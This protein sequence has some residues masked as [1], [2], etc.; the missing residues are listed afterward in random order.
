MNRIKSN[1]LAAFAVFGRA[2][3]LSPDGNAS[4]DKQKTQSANS[5]NVE[6]KS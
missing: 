2:F 3:S 6:Q 5:L 1:T 4:P